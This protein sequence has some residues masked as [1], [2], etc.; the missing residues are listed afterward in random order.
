LVVFRATD[1]LWANAWKKYNGID[2]SDDMVFT[3]KKL[4]FEVSKTEKDSLMDKDVRFDKYLPSKPKQ[5]DH[6]LVIACTV[7]SEL[8][9]DNAR[10]M[11]IRALW[12]NAKDYIVIVENGGPEGYRIVTNARQMLIDLAGKRDASSHIVAPC[13]HEG[14]CPLLKSRSLCELPVMAQVTKEMALYS[15]I[16]A[17]LVSLKMSF[18]V[19]R[20]QPREKKEVQPARVLNRTYGNQ[21]VVMDVCAE[22]GEI[23]QRIFTKKADPDFKRHKRTRIGDLV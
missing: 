5:Q 23:E 13:T 21:K 11:I 4:L 9:N 15:T 1:Y 10:S 17:N 8:P 7:L 18:V 22:S 14:I 6:D 12:D 2:I 16:K 3:A 20:K 19:F